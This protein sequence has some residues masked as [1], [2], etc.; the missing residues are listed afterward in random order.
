MAD[1]DTQAYDAETIVGIADKGHKSRGIASRF[2]TLKQAIIVLAARGKPHRQRENERSPAEWP[3]SASIGPRPAFSPG[4]VSG[5]PKLKTAEAVVKALLSKQQVQHDEMRRRLQRLERV[6]GPVGSS[7]DLRQAFANGDMI[8]GTTRVRQAREESGSSTEPAASVR[9]DNVAK[10]R[11]MALGRLTGDIPPR[12]IPVDPL[13]AGSNVAGVRRHTP[14]PRAK[15]AE[16]AGF[17]R[18][19][20]LSPLQQVSGSRC[21]M[22]SVSTVSSDTTVGTSLSSLSSRS[23]TTAVSRVSSIDDDLDAIAEVAT[24]RLATVIESRVARRITIAGS[25]S[26]AGKRETSV[27]R[28]P[29]RAG[30][31]RPAERESHEVP[32]LGADRYDE[33]PPVSRGR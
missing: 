26:V 1:V 22:E 28:G 5:T 9:T 18:F 20:P 13:A 27:D 15:N 2:N 33:R 7:R 16:P 4:D 6:T 23:S 30:I 14:Y 10:H 32:A 11:A 29:A 8:L 21:S 25:T 19:V 3:A 31:D 24:A 17:D 12:V